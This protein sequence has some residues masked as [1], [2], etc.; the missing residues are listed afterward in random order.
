[1]K[2]ALM[3]A[4]LAL[5]ILYAGDYLWVRYRILKARDP[6]GTVKIQ[7]YYAVRKKDRKTEFV[8]V[9]VEG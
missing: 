5:G 1:M 6:F 3:V 2:R 9:V 7:R 8:V 4:G